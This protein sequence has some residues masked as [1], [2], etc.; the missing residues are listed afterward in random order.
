MSPADSL[1]STIGTELLDD[2]AAD[3]ALVRESLR[4]LA[5][6]NRWFGGVWAARAGVRRLLG[7]SRP[8]QLRLFDIGTGQGDIPLAMAGWLGRLGVS[9]RTT[10]IDF[11]RAA[12]PLARAHGVTVAVAD[13]FQLPF[14]DRAFDIVMMSQFVH[15]F[16]AEGIIRLCREASR[17][18][19]LGVVIADL[20]RTVWA[21]TAFGLA[22]RVL[23]FDHY[24][25]VD[26]ITSLH[27]GFRLGEL[28]QAIQAAGFRPT[29]TAEL[30]ARV[31]AT[32]KTES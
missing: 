18:A 29:V 22:S 17:T 21:A 32:W 10:G 5:R 26:G 25:R 13:A 3:P 30:G 8:K 7:S 14:A 28:G 9:L 1:Q 23:G 2:R 4:H 31:V 15:H 20:R 11:H 19:R 6:S 24:T 12:A 27:R 16:S